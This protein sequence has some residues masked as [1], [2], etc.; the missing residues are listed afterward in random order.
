MHTSIKLPSAT[1]TGASVWLHS[2]TSC[3]AAPSRGETKQLISARRP[4]SSSVYTARP[5]ANHGLPQAAMLFGAPCAHKNTR[6]PCSRNGSPAR[7]VSA[8]P[9]AERKPLPRASVAYVMPPPA[10]ICVSRG[11]V[12]GSGVRCAVPRSCRFG[13]WRRTRESERIAFLPG[14]RSSSSSAYASTCGN[15]RK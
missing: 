14:A 10:R 11:K 6:G 15:W 4:F 3:I 7:A 8:S 5:R 12:P 1:R 2:S 13:G 9:F